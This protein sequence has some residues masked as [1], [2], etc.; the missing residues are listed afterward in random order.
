M[1]HHRSPDLRPWLVCWLVGWLKR[2]DTKWCTS[3]SGLRCLATIIDPFFY[4]L[5]RVSPLR[6]GC[7][8]IPKHQL[9]T[10]GDTCLVHLSD[11]G[12]LHRL[13]EHACGDYVVI[14]L[15][16]YI[17]T[18]T[19]CS[20]LIKPKKTIFCRRPAKKNTPG[21][22][23]KEFLGPSRGFGTTEVAPTRLLPRWRGRVDAPGVEVPLGADPPFW[24][25]GA[26][27]GRWTWRWGEV[28][29]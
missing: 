5:R 28:G 3:N 19:C 10:S 17:P 26:H 15:V 6:L 21:A 1:T 12:C 29:E 7:L 2:G 14:L 25:L 16:H 4:S 13:T 24:R 20:C 11:F 23:T 18:H 9:P 22:P 27:R 8:K